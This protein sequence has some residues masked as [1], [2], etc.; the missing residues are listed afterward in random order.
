MSVW[1][2]FT[3]AFKS[4]S[5]ASPTGSSGVFY[6]AGYY[7]APVT[8]VTLTNISPTQTY[9]GANHA[10]A[11]HAFIV[12][13]GAGSTDA[14]TVSI[15]VSGTSITDNGVRTGSDSETIM[16]DITT[17]VLN[18]YLETTKK[19]IGQ[20]TYT[21]TGAGG[22]S[23]FTVDVN[24]GL[25]KYDDYANQNFLLKSFECEGRAGADDTGFGID[26][27]HHQSTGWVYHATAFVPGSITTPIASMNTDTAPENNLAN[28]ENF[29]YKRANLSTYIQGGNEEGFI[30][31]IT[32]SANRA[33][34]AMDCHIGVNV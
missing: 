15:V 13:G 11:A 4:F 28:G 18:Q 6:I 22:A 10:H 27:L 33:V 20:I 25:C 5:F 30:I 1:T 3:K 29:A 7:D 32:T 12:L 26:L 2:H 14:G 16:T 19:W 24:Y 21:L 23:T 34:E 8:K 9:G 17:G 31:K